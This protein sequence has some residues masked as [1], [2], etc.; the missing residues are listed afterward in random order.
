[1]HSSKGGLQYGMGEEEQRISDTYSGIFQRMYDELGTTL[2][3][4]LS[5]EL[6]LKD[7]FVLV[8][9]PAS[10]KRLLISCVHLQRYVTAMSA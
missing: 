8:R 6:E 4:L 10:E 9:F 3:D 5:E 1:M 7:L 2:D